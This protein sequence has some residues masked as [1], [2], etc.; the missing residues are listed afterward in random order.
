MLTKKAKEEQIL[1]QKGDKSQ[2][3]AIIKNEI[4]ILEDQITR[5]LIAATI[6][7]AQEAQRGMTALA[8]LDIIFAKSS[9][10]C[11]WNGVVPE[12][13]K[14]GRLNV[15]QF[16][17]PVLALEG[18]ERITP[19]DLIMPANDEGRALMISGPN[20]GGKTLALKSF[21]LTAMMV[22]L[23]LPIT[24]SQPSSEDNM[25][26]PP[27]I[28]DYFEDI[29]VEVGDS[30]SISKHESTLMARLNA[31]SSLI[32]TLSSSSEGE[33][34]LVLLDELGGGTDPNAGAAIAQ[35]ILEVLI[36]NQSSCKIVATT[37]SPQLKVLSVNDSRFHCASVLMNSDK[38][39][40]TFQ[41]SYGTTGESF[42]L[43]AARRANPSL[44][45]HV[46]DR[47]AELMNRGEADAVDSLNHYLSALENE[48]QAAKQLVQQTKE[49]LKEVS[50]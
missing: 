10:G 11:E 5:Q 45:D 31:L 41:L 6:R 15:E 39:N 40:P 46:L 43:E 2:K 9:F 19:V 36:S 16:I 22:K 33:A 34:Q 8:R 24:I 30:Q 26:I 7:G 25:N 1:K 18:N 23:S 13:D 48:Q 27:P 50:E 14:K 44:P 35:S 21:G 49:T 20:G 29:L 32:H 47:A 4:S 42:A 17:H 12:I 3:L 37:H 28:V 38:T